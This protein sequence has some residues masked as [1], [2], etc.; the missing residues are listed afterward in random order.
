MRLYYYQDLIAH[1]ETFDQTVDSFTS[2]EFRTGMQGPLPW[3]HPSVS[4]AITNRLTEIQG[5]QLSF[6]SVEGKNTSITRLFPRLEAMGDTEYPEPPAA[7]HAG[8]SA[9]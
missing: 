2:G 1:V 7:E 3:S 9:A 8:A 6:S 4:E 5:E